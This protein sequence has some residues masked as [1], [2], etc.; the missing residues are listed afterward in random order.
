MIIR[1]KDGV[2]LE[3][4]RRFG[5]RTGKEYA[6][7]GERCMGAGYEYQHNWYHKFSSDPETGKVSYADDDMDQPMVQISVRRETRELYVDCTPSCTY[8]IGGDDLEVLINTVM[9]L[10]KFGLLEVVNTNVDQE[11]EQEPEW[12]RNIRNK[13]EDVK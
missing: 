11:I 12:K 2:D 10:T 3:N 1:I 4:L 7:A 9:D 13:F 6:D 5:F 8:H